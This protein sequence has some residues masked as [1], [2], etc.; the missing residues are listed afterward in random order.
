MTGQPAFEKL[1]ERCSIQR[2]R[3]EFCSV[4]GKLFAHFFVH[5]PVHSETL[6]VRLF[7]HRLFVAKVARD[8]VVE[9]TD[10]L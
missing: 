6:V 1:A 4:A 7:H 5:L 8:I 10:D 2:T 9:L 3:R